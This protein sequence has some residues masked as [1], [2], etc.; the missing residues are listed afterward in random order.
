[1]PTKEEITR[2][3]L[4][5]DPYKRNEVWRFLTYMFI[6]ED[7]VHITM[8]VLM[9]LFVGIPLEMSQPG[10]IGTGRVATV[11]FSGLIFGILGAAL[12]SPNDYVCGASGAVCALIWVHLGIFGIHLFS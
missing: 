4:I 3:Y 7:N 11:Y 1:M 2:S 5:Y 10:W 9:Q 6:H 8:N 12:I